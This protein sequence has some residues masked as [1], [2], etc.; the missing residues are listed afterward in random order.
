MKL[1][2]KIVTGI[3]LVN[4]LASTCVACSS[5]Q[6]QELDATMPS[7]VSTVTH[8]DTEYFEEINQE[9]ET[10]TVD[11]VAY[12]AKRNQTI[13]NFVNHEET[14]L[15]F[16]LEALEHIG[17]DNCFGGKEG[18]IRS[19]GQFCDA[20]DGVIGNSVELSPY[21]L[22]GRDLV[23][24]FMS[25]AP[26]ELK[27]DE[28]FIRGLI[29]GGDSGSFRKYI[30]DWASDELKSD[31]DFLKSVSRLNHLPLLDQASEE[32][33]QNE[34]FI[35]EMIRVCAFNINYVDE[36][37][38]NDKAFL[39]NAIRVNYDVLSQLK[40]PSDFGFKDFLGDKDFM[41]QVIQ[42]SPRLLRY[43]FDS[44][45][46]MNDK[47]FILEAISIN[48]PT[49]DYFLEYNPNLKNDKELAVG[50]MKLANERFEEQAT[51]IKEYLF[52]D[53][54][55]CETYFKFIYDDLLVY[56]SESVLADEAFKSEYE[57]FVYGVISLVPEEFLKD[58]NLQK[59][60][61]SILPNY[62]FQLDKEIEQ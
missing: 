13:L 50:V 4:F 24:K 6:K 62:E 42:I 1:R 53:I 16:Y 45:K 41:L 19:M 8:Q 17:F 36:K 48:L 60:I 7:I 34:D 23:L 49:L 51:D 22:M 61:K 33:R 35:L 46:L 3:L 14:R 58:T 57:K 38:K 29:S 26:D 44:T 20:L 5:T 28:Q 2:N 27:N 11:Y 18:F 25:C 47:S 37:L 56:F 40:Q 21:R 54:E 31:G 10:Y 32:L 52:R 9:K 59:T 39:L 30:M 15:S 55:S 12:A 43:A